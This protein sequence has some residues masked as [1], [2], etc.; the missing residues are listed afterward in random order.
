MEKQQFAWRD[1]VP[2]TVVEGLMEA[3]I[4]KSK[5]D[6][7]EIPCHLRFESV[8]RVIG[9]TMDGLGKVEIMVLPEHRQKALDILDASSDDL[10]DAANNGG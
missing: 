1:Y 9:I 7:F 8:G 2:L 5:L 6:S 10:S 3:E 4:I